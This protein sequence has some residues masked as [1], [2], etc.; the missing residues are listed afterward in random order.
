M[1]ETHQARLSHEM[2]AFRVELEI[3]KTVAVVQLQLKLPE[4]FEPQKAGNLRPGLAAHVGE[5]ER[6]DA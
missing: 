4:H 1:K 3:H 6:D 5:V 2:H